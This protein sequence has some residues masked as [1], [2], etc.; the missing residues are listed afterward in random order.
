MIPD[1]WRDD[2]P[3]CATTTH[4]TLS[5]VKIRLSLSDLHCCRNLFT[6][7]A[8]QNFKVLYTL[9]C[10]S[11][12][13]FYVFMFSALMLY[14]SLLFHNLL[15]SDKYLRWK[16]VS[17]TR[18]SDVWDDF[19]GSSRSRTSRIYCKTPHCGTVIHRVHSSIFIAR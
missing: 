10:S 7:I 9:I 6:E 12:T 15:E 3:R 17:K 1:G 8:I 19:V 16:I 13:K 2:W 11:L 4:S 18:P 14:L 5:P